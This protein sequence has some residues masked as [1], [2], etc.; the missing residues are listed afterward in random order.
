M[1]D[2]LLS[3]I[4][5]IIRLDFNYKCSSYVCKF[6]GKPLQYLHKHQVCWYNDSR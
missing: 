1:V 6:Q 5:M 3:N 4:T 2:K